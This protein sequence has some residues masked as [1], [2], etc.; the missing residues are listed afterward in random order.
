MQV[1]HCNLIRLAGIDYYF[2]VLYDQCRLHLQIQVQV[3]IGVMQ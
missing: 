1:N 2:K 3:L